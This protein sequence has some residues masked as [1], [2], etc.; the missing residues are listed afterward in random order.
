MSALDV[1]RKAAE[2]LDSG[3]EC[4]IA[5]LTETGGS[6][7]QK[8]GAK[9]LIYGDG[10]THGTIGGGDVERKLIE[11]VLTE[12]PRAARVV[13]YQLNED[14]HATDDPKMSCGGN[15]TFYVEPLLAAHRLFIVGGGH[16]GV[17]LSRLA[18]QVGFAVT[19]LDH[20]AEWANRDKHPQAR[21][22]CAPYDD[23]ARHIAFSANAY[24]VIMTHGHEHDER[25]LRDCLDKEYRYL[26]VIGSARKAAGMFKRLQEDGISDALLGRVHCPI[27][28]PIPSHTPAEIA[29]SIAAELIAVKNGA[30][31]KN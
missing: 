8:A 24:I 5:I 18:A 15:V 9:M 17:E 19:V 3:R 22:V 26:G 11:D 13:R 25:V 4:F 10:A 28:V 2:A 14:A 16:C 6:T 12:R 27:G 31:E 23:A 30:E 20:R 7:P 21:V 29:V 1:Y